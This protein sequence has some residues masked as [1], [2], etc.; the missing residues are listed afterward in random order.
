MS[1]AVTFTAKRNEGGE[2]LTYAVN[3]HQSKQECVT[4]EAQL[5]S[6][7]IRLS[8]GVEIEQKE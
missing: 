5:S 7:T 8:F 3:M 2:L 6:G 4:A 1:T